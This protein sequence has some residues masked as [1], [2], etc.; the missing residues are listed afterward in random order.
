MPTPMSRLL[1]PSSRAVL[2]GLWI[3]LT[4]TALGPTGCTSESSDGTTDTTRGGDTPETS[5]DSDA[6]D[7]SLDADVA[8]PDVEP[9]PGCWPR[10]DLSRCADAGWTWYSDRATNYCPNP[11]ENC[12]PPTDASFC[13]KPCGDDSDCAGTTV[14]FCGPIAWW[15]SSDHYHCASFRVCVP[16]KPEPSWCY[17]PREEDRCCTG[18][19]CF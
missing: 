11:G 1:T 17:H 15:G 19:P 4:A 9:T 6:V 10:F 8:T 18:F 5:P 14:P 7:V 3:S 13:A 16:L 2:I 12:P